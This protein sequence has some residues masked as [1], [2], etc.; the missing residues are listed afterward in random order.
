MLLREPTMVLRDWTSDS[1]RWADVPLLPG[2]IVVAT[3]P[4]CGTTWTQRIIGMLLR[5]SA[6]P[7][8]IQDS[9]P[10]ID[11]RIQ[12][13]EPV[14]DALARQWD[15]V[16]RRSMKTH[17]PLTA[18][19]LHDDVLYVH[20]TRDPR[21]ACM[22][23]HNHVGGY[24]DGARAMMDHAGLS[25]ETIG[26]PCPPFR[27]D[28][29]AFFR[30]FLEQADHAPFTEFTIRT[31]CALGASYWA[32]RHRPNVL[33]VHYN[34]LKA[35]LDGE[36]RRIADFCDIAVDP[37]LW[38]DLVAAADFT[39]MKRDGAALMPGA[40]AI[41]HGGSDR[42]LNRGTNQRWRGIL[43]ADDLVAYDAIAAA[44]MSPALRAWS[45]A[46][47]LVVGDPRASAD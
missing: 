38:P 23:F 43:S 11:L 10:W 42:F 12:P 28:P 41:W 15:S 6:A 5:Q 44:G 36:M 39:A 8:A 16:G 18:L 31:Y 45:E 26:A 4:K 47:R 7:F 3:S 2:D 21:D 20:V 27:P 19:P 34:D 9:Y 35:D 46:G 24:T 32:E 40:A 17:S 29:Q 37:G 14:Q 33:L 22:S 13:I 30:A 1:R 25:D